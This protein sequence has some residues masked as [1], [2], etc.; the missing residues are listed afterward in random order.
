M[1]V[2]QR[3]SLRKQ[4]ALSQAEGRRL[5]R[6]IKKAFREDRQ[7]RAK[8]TGHA[9]MVA[10]LDGKAR[11]AWGTVRAWQR[12]CNPAASKPCYDAL[13]DQTRKREDLYRRRAPPATASPPAPRAHR[14]TTHHP[15]TRSS[16]RQPSLP[17][18]GYRAG[19]PRCGRRI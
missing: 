2:D 17:A 1:L 11:E 5:S 15:R 14:V 9:I 6:L 7:E 4:G 19:L 18:M 10:L 3:S 12:K 16:G 13:E 8:V